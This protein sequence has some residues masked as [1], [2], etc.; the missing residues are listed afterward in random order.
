VP[1][2]SEDCIKET[3]YQV[4]LLIRGSGDHGGAEARQL[5]GGPLGPRGAKSYA[6]VLLKRNSIASV[7]YEKF[8]EWSDGA[9]TAIVKIS[10]GQRPFNP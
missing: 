4:F 3:G 9:N 6:E 10:N 5:Y 2:S 8:Q 1:I 7:P